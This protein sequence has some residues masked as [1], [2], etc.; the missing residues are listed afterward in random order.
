MVVVKG[1]FGRNI[2]AGAPIRGL[3]ETEAKTLK[4]CVSFANGVLPSQKAS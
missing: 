1:G 3:L 4:Q 2:T